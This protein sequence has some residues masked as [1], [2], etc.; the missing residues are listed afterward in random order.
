MDEITTDSLHLVL[1]VQKRGKPTAASTAHYQR[2]LEEY[3]AQETAAKEQ[4]AA[5]IESTLNLL[6]DWTS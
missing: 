2:D 6:D 5:I 3:R 4:I 1:P